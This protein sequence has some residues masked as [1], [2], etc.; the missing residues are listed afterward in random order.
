MNKQTAYLT[1]QGLEKLQSEHQ[2]LKSLRKIKLG[3][4]APPVLDS[5]DLSAEFIAF[6]DDLDYIDSRIAELEHILK[7]Y[8]LITP[9]KKNERGRVRLGA[10]VT[11]SINDHTD[12]YQIVGT[13]EANPSLGKISNES[14]VG[15]ALLGSKKGD[16]VVVESPIRVVYKIKKI[17][18]L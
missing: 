18:Y 13:L 1:K 14:P 17:E 15:K 4:E 2:K 16:E 8:Q 9:P 5:E 10:F 3:K 6:R 11:I 7:R 12:Q